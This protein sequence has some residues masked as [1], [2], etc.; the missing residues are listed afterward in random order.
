MDQKDGHLK[1]R[2]HSFEV[3]LNGA[4]SSTLPR[5]QGEPACPDKECNRQPRQLIGHRPGGLRRQLASGQTPV[6]ENSKL[7]AQGARMR[8]EW[9]VG[10]LL[11]L[12]VGGVASWAF[13]KVLRWW[14]GVPSKL[15]LADGSRGIPPWLTGVIERLF[16]TVLVGLAISGAPAAMIGWLAL[17]LATNWNHPDWKDKA[18]ARTFALS[19]L[20]GGLVSM[21]FA[22]L[23]GLVCSRTL[24]L[25]I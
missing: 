17:K 15:R 4:K 18:N 20:L 19:A 3:G 9:I 8:P 10:L 14:L 2:I 11:S 5:S 25:G 6:S 13:L 21:F 24:S 16:F 1:G 22:L 12:V 23:G 7:D